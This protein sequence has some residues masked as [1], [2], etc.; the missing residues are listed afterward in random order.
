MFVLTG[1]CSCICGSVNIDFIHVALLPAVAGYAAV[2]SM[3]PIAG[4][5]PIPTLHLVN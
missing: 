5:I 1:H 4:R 3:I 2:A